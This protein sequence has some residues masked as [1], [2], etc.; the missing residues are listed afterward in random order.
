V[1]FS[2][3]CFT[4]MPS[5]ARFSVLGHKRST[6]PFGPFGSHLSVYTLSFI[7][8]RVGFTHIAFGNLPFCGSPLGRLEHTATRMFTEHSRLTLWPFRVRIPASIIPPKTPEYRMVFR[9]FWRREWDS[10]PRSLTD[11]AFRVLYSIGHLVK[12]TA[13]MRSVDTG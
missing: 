13:Q 6:G 10:N 4:N 9:G 2:H 1:G 12:F 8:Q 3:V 7:L 5:C 11:T